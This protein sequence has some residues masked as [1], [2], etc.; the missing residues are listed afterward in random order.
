[1]SV[2]AGRIGRGTPRPPF[3]GSGGSGRAFFVVLCGPGGRRVVVVVFCVVVGV[4]TVVVVTG[5]TEVAASARP[6]RISLPAGRPAW[7]AVSV[8]CTAVTEA[9]ASVAFASEPPSSVTR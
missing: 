4:V 7:S 9:R 3:G 5:G 2:G 1:M 8:T 6:T